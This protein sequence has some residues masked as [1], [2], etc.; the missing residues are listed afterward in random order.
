MAKVS[1]AIRVDPTSSHLL[2]MAEAAALRHVVPAHEVLVRLLLDL[3]READS[4]GTVDSVIAEAEVERIASLAAADVAVLARV[5]AFD[6]A[7]A[8]TLSFLMSQ[9]MRSLRRRSDPPRMILTYLNPNVGFT[10][11]SYR[12]ANWVLWGHEADTRYAYLDGRYVT[13]RE[14]TRRF[15]SAE[16]SV[17]DSHLSGRIA[18]SR[19]ALSPLDVY[20]YPIDTGLRDPLTHSEPVNLSRPRT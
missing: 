16:P 19:M 5:Y 6:W 2:E 1:D 13:D 9:L 8:N 17:L 18:F 4:D 20:A 10:G 15:G 7:P 3:P 12:A 11:A 14:L